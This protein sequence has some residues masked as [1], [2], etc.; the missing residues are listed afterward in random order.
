MFTNCKSDFSLYFKLLNVHIII[1]GIWNFPFRM[2]EKKSKF[3]LQQQ[4][5][6]NEIILLI[7]CAQPFLWQSSIR[8]RLHDNELIVD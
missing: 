2:F 8:I 3:K 5:K 1:S 7:I 6:I 4:I